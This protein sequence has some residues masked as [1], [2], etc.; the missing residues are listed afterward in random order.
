MVRG[1]RFCTW[2]GSVKSYAREKP[3]RRIP[4][5]LYPSTAGEGTL[6]FE[7]TAHQSDVEVTEYA[8]YEIVYLNPAQT[9]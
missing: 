2:R 9:A 7:F 8:F 4:T 1:S 6:L 3:C 5:Q